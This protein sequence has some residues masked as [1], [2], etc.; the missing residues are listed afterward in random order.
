MVR[1]TEMQFRLDTKQHAVAGS[2]FAAI[3]IRGVW[4]ASIP[5]LFS[6]KWSGSIANVF[7]FGASEAVELMCAVC[8]CGNM[9]ISRI[10]FRWGFLIK[11]KLK[12]WPQVQRGIHDN[13]SKC[14][15]YGYTKH[16]HTHIFSGWSFRRKRVNEQMS[17]CRC[18][19]EWIVNGI[20]LFG[21]EFYGRIKIMSVYY[22]LTM[23]KIM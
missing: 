6:A 10:L 13:D 18:V 11:V 19:M 2:I 5:F 8:V 21:S 16:T 12:F 4:N 20:P 9:F 14:P 17:L 1:L 22:G 15:I 3:E 7:R 23:P